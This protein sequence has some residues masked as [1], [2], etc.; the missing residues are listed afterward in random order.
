MGTYLDID[1]DPNEISGKGSI[2]R[3][4][5]ESFRAK[6]QAILGDIHAV[7]A[8]RPWGNDKYGHAFETTY[9]QI[10]PGGETSLRD[11]VQDGL[12]HAGERLTKVGDKTVLAMTEYQGID[13]DNGA[14]IR[15]A[16]KA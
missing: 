3:S 8:Q 13:G 10:P 6:A 15:K 7:D 11:M 14:E 1:G 5:A 4:L 12:S 16:A 9:N 2:L